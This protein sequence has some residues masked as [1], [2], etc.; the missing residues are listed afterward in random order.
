MLAQVEAN[1]E[2]FSQTVAIIVAWVGVLLAFVVGTVLVRLGKRPRLSKILFGLCILLAIASIILTASERALEGTLRGVR[3]LFNWGSVLVV[4]GVIVGA[5][6]YNAVLRWCVRG[7]IGTVRKK[8]WQERLL[9]FLA[10]HRRFKVIRR[11][12]AYCRS[13]EQMLGRAAKE[14]GSWVSDDRARTMRTVQ[15]PAELPATGHDGDEGLEAYLRYIACTYSTIMLTN[16]KYNRLVYLPTDQDDKFSQAFARSVE[17]ARGYAVE[18][19]FGPYANR[20]KRRIV[21]PDHYRYRT[22]LS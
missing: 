16:W 8:Q 10:G 15:T 4:V 7:S 22:V 21:V 12:P 1:H 9:D 19:C 14:V 11:F 20:E 5:V 13:C 18:C 6:G 3:A 2:A 17:F